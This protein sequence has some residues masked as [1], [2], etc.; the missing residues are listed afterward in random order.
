MSKS[1]ERAERLEHFEFKFGPLRGRVAAAIDL[2]SDAQ[3]AVGTHAAY[4]KQPRDPDRPTRDIEEVLERLAAVK[5]LLLDVQRR[6]QQPRT[7][8]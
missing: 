4:C 8:P 7:P 3:I 6:L 1:D 2:L 5:D